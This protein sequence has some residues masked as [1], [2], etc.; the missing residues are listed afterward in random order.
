M[1]AFAF[2]AAAPVESV[3]VPKMVPLAC[4]ATAREPLNSNMAVNRILKQAGIGIL[5]EKSIVH[6]CIQVVYSSPH[7]VFLCVQMRN[8]TL[9]SRQRAY[10]FLRNKILSGELPAGTA[11]SE[12]ALARD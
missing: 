8:T 1:I 5:L 3:T 2:A 4:W 7:P 12:L 10:E 9:S 11:L 6:F